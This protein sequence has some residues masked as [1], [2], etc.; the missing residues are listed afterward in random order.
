MVSQT[1]TSPGA[2]PLREE[3]IDGFDRIARRYDLLTRMN[4]GY[5]KHLRWSARRLGLPPGA[6]ILDLC[7]GTG[8]STAAIARVYPDARE[9][10]GL[11]ASRG[12]LDIARANV[13]LD[14]VRFVQGNAM[15]PAAAGVTED[16]AHFDGILMA[17]GI[18]NVPDPDACLARLFELLAPGAPICFHEYS[19][20]DSALARAVW[21]AVSLGVILPS[22]VAM[23]RR[24]D[25]WLYL[26]RSVN[27][28]DGVRA[29]EA[30]LRRHGFV[31]VETRPMDGWQRGILH[32]F[33]ARRPA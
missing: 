17:Y 1:T 19:V 14:H 16:G 23:T 31:G 11:D 3:V 30:R 7:C 24:A 2:A 26:R 5:V 18:R 15:D 25:M 8:L 12:M 32:S 29:F 28:F 9:I 6:R 20:V 33:M 22:G 13:A 4:P 21:N 10:I 27:E